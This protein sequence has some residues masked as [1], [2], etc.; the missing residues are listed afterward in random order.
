[1]FLEN[2]NRIRHPCGVF[3]GIDETKLL[4]LIDLR[5]DSFTFGRMD[6]HLFVA[7]KYGIR[8]SVDMMFDNGGI[9]VREFQNKTRQKH[10]GIP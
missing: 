7:D 8:P 10:H 4:D 5:F 9:E 1:L 6:R 3:S 2:N